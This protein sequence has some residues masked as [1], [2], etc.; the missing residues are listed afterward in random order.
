MHIESKYT[1]VL[2]AD[3]FQ[4]FKK[5]LGSSSVAMQW[6]RTSVSDNSAEKAYRHEAPTAARLLHG[7]RQAHPTDAL[8]VA[9]AAA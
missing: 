4:F 7:R 2:T 9:S 6:L 3:V 5:Y 8:R 1:V